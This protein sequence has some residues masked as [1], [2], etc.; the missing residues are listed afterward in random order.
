M[1]CYL[2]NNLEATVSFKEKKTAKNLDHVQTKLCKFK[3]Y[4]N[5]Y[6]IQKDLQNFQ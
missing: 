6:N 2:Q 1:E 3:F 4:K 5:A